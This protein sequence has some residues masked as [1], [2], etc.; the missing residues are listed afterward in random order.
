MPEALRFCIPARSQDTTLQHDKLGSVHARVM[1]N[2]GR[3]SLPAA[4]HREAHGADWHENLAAG[5]KEHV[6][7]EGGLYPDEGDHRD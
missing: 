1:H 6:P 5:G 7:G 4:R 3:G 2:Q